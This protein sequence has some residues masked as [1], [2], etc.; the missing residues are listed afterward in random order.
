MTSIITWNVNGI[1]AVQ[2]KGF[3]QWL[4]EEDPDILCIQE[5]KAHPDQLDEEL[6][7]PDLYKSYW[8][9]AE[10]KGYSGLVTYSKSA[11]LK[12]EPLGIEEFDREGRVQV[13]YYPQF[14]LINAYFPNSQEKGKRVDYKLRFCDALL[15]FCNDLKQEGHHL[16]LCGDYNIAHKRIDLKNPDSNE[17]N[18]GFLP[19]ERAWMDRFVQEGYVDTFRLFTQEGDHYTWW[20]Y[21]T[22]ARQRNAGW[23]IDYH[24]VDEGFAS[25]IRDCTILKDIL[26]SD[27]CP[28]KLQL[29]EKISQ[30]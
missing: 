8:A 10:K 15:R 27:H 20:S 4:K 22:R 17:D 28:V 23:R 18:P 12:V 14:T 2:K 11:P 9:S 16:V 19:E 13:L 25:Q 29:K 1:R 6:I 24:C 21:R 26:G 7:K 3:L 30:A 5:T